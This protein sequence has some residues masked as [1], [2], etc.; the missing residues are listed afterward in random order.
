L[1][2]N[3]GGVLFAYIPAMFLGLHLLYEEMKLDSTLYGELHHLANLL[4]RIACKLSYCKK[5]KST[6]KSFLFIRKICKFVILFFCFMHFI[7]FLEFLYLMV[8]TVCASCCNRL[9]MPSFM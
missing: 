9:V 5:F 1:Q 6:Q 8:I 7:A 3:P 2:V 4:S